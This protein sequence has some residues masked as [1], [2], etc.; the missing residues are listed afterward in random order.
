MNIS[1]GDFHLKDY[2]KCKLCSRTDTWD[3]VKA[4]KW[5][6]SVNTHFIFGFMVDGFK[7]WYC[8]ECTRLYSSP[9][10]YPY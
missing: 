2:A 8:P 5:G 9:H 1:M 10:P 7:R 6:Y 3:H 4:D